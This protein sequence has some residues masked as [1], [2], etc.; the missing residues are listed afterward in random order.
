V[1]VARN[2]GIGV[3]EG[4]YVSFLDADDV[5]ASWHLQTIDRLIR[6]APDAVAWCTSY[7][8]FSTLTD[9]DANATPPETGPNRSFDT[10][11]ALQAMAR[12]QLIWTGCVTVNRKA[13]LQIT[14]CFPPGEQVGEDIDC[15]FRVVQLGTLRKSHC[16]TA[17]YRTGV[18]G[19]LTTWKHRF[20]NP[21]IFRLFSKAG[22]GDAD[23]DRGVME[24]VHRH[25]LDVAYHCMI[26]RRSLLA[27]GYL[28]EV[29]F[30]YQKNY[31]TSTF[32]GAVVSPAASRAAIRLVR[33][34]K[35]ILRSLKRR[36]PRSSV[37]AP[38]QPL[39]LD[40]IHKDGPT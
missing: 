1:S 6:E 23:F 38:G 10:S 2:F 21:A 13:L 3:A 25:L 29:P 17:F 34:V 11:A 33:T 18:P 36:Q 8:E 9:L 5:W 27:L 19:S 37:K 31:W 26:Q 22:R 16:V 30:N 12:H 15:W 35:S 4:Q 7:R 32:I 39:C 40:A 24:N 20:P 14:P 28:F